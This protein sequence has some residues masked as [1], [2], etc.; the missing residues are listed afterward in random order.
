VL[1]VGP[2]GAASR[3]KLV[4]NLILGLHRAVLAEGLTLARAL[5]FDAT[6]A[7]AM[8]GQTPAR[9][10]VMDAKGP[11]MAAGDFAPQAT[12]AQHL[13]D[14]RLMLDAARLAG[15]ALPLSACHERLLDSV[16]AAGLGGAD[17]SAIITA[18]GK[19]R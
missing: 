2:L 13:K 18:F 14:V 15:I 11:K 19:A 8:L 12:V 10:A 16:V 3:F 5:G 7:L 9:S 6:T 17:N 4:H 1:E